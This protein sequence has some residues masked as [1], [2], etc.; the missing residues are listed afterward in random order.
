[1]DIFSFDFIVFYFPRITFLGSRALA[2]S[3]VDIHGS[4]ATLRLISVI[5]HYPVHSRGQLGK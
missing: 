1:M 4:S 2:V 3:L 5:E